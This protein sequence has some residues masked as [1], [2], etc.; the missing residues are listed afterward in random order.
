MNGAAL[1]GGF[2]DAPR[3]A[4]FAFRGLMRAMARPGSIET[5]DGAAP[6][7]PLSIAAGTLLLTLADGDTPVHLAGSADTADIRGW[8]GFHTGAPIVPP[9]TAVFAVGRWEALQPLTAFAIGTPEYPD[10]S[11][12]LIV[13]CDTLDQTGSRLTGPGIKD[14]AMLS[15]PD[16]EALARN[17]AMFPLGLDIY[18]TC[19]NRVAALPRSTRI[20]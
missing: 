3:A 4:S 2:T 9:G 17:H 13:E 10:R 1:E 7:A 5:V 6:P 11:A 20:G 8:L 15:L 14:S 16:P 18:F 12:T 19:G